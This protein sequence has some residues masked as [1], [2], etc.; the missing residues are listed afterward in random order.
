MTDEP[1][2]IVVGG[3]QAGLVAGH[4]LANARI[5]FKILDA[6]SRVGDAWRH[7]WDSLTLFT[8]ARYSALPGL[9]FPGDPEHF[10]G[11]DEV[12]DYLEHYAQ[13]FELPVALDTRVRSLEPDGDGYTL[14]TTTGTYQA[15]QMIVATGAYQK[16]YVPPIAQDLDEDV[17][18]LH[19]ADYGNPDQITG[20]RV[21]VVGAAN[22]GAGIAE[23]LAATHRVALSVGTKLPH[24][25]PRLLG[26]S[27]HFWGDH[28]GLIGAS[29][30]SWRGRTQ[31]GDL[32]VGPSLRRLS[33]RH[34]I[35]LVGRTYSARGHTVRLQGQRDI[36]V[37]SIVWATGYRPDYTWIHVDGLFDDAGFPIHRRGVTNAAGLYFLGMKDQYSR[38]SSL[39]YWVK[40]DAAHIVNQLN[41]QSKTNST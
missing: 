15:A 28:L 23:D 10:P 14:D 36:E 35:E 26:K 7:R 16:P 31:R 13:R 19:S 32:L 11:K 22:S 3:S 12:A 37:D 1:K 20:R 17:L 25:P 33:R 30:D 40:D 2:V 9:A 38:G 5:P 6:A 29:L 41:T 39:I 34:G 21:L 4:Y 18:Q 24:L 8:A 27:L